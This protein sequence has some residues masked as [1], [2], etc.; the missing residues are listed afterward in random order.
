MDLIIKG[1]VSL[2]FTIASVALIFYG[3]FRI[4][5]SKMLSPGPL[6][7]AHEKLDKKGECNACHTKGKKL[8][9]D[10]CLNCHQDIKSMIQRKSG[11]HARVTTEC[12]RCHSEHHSRLFNM[13]HFDEKSFDHS[14]V[15]SPLG[16]KHLLL[17]C[18]VCHTEGSYLINENKCFHCHEDIHK[19]GMGENCHECHNQNNFKEAG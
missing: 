4:N 17:R 10:K 16:G 12:A 1:A 11:L 9:T 7:Y 6:S 19:G 15:G 13:I 18:E 8:D 14:M 2:I 5:W 3:G